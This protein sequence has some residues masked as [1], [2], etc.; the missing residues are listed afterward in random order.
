MA[1]RIL[2]LQECLHHDGRK[3]WIEMRETPGQFVPVC[4]YAE[5]VPFLMFDAQDRVLMISVRAEM[6]GKTWRCW[7]AKPAVSDW[8]PVKPEKKTTGKK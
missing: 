3:I 4:F 8:T 6:Y 7:S 1:Y 2:K 5:H